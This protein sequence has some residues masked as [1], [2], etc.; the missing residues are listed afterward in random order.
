MGGIGGVFVDRTD[1]CIILNRQDVPE[2]DLNA[3]RLAPQIIEIDT[4]GNLVNSWSNPLLEPRLHCHY[5]DKDNIICGSPARPQA[6]C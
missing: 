1:E 4:A 5:F 2:A 6:W 3:G